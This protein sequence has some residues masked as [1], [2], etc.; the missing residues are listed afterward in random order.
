MEPLKKFPIPPD[1]SGYTFTDPT[2]ILMVQ[3]EGGQSRFRR[4][5]LNSDFRMNV[6]WTLNSEEYSFYRIF[7]NT[8]ITRGCDPFLMDL[9]VDDGETLTEHRC[10]FIPGTS[11]LKS[12]QGKCFVVGATL[13]V[14]PITT[15]LANNPA[16]K[17]YQYDVEKNNQADVYAAFGDFSIKSIDKF[18]NL[19]N[20][21]IPADLA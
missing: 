10:H 5:I 12:Q 2:E 11:G 4:D 6:Q 15:A 20:V 21:Q 17:N 9:Y 16:A 7:Y 13:E 8:L 19:M 18:D 14:H 1:Q 3:L